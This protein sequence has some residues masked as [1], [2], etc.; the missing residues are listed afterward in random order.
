MRGHFTN[1]SDLIFMVS[2]YYE[3]PSITGIISNTVGLSASGAWKSRSAALIKV[4]VLP[5]PWVC[6]TRP[7]R[8]T[9]ST[10]PVWC[11]RRM[12][13]CSSSSFSAKTM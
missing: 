7:R 1:I 6:Q 12:Y 2:I 9:C 10:A 11:R 5:L 3:C 13:L 8:T 4:K